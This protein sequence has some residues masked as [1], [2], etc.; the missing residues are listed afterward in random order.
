MSI[1][2]P[3]S[4]MLTCIRNGQLSNKR[5]VKLPSSKIK[6]AIVKVLKKE[7][8]IKNYKIEGNIK[9]TLEIVL[10]YF[11]C[12]GVIESIQRIS[13]PSIRIYKKKN[14]LPKVMN[15]LG[16]AIISTSKGVMTDSEAR[17]SG[18]GGEILCYIT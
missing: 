2:D 4:D 8:Y 13:R 9:L 1:H 14:E 12:K 3:I 17:K 6:E 15:G 10:K 5:V 7:G 16:I 18:L 11:K